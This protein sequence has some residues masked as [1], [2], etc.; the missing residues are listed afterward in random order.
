MPKAC[1]CTCKC[2]LFCDLSPN[3]SPHGEGNSSKNPSPTSEDLPLKREG[4]S[5]RETNSAAACFACGSR[6]APA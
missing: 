6:E 5:L 3:P 1:V 2:R 4:V